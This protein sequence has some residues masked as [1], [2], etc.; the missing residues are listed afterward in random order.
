MNKMAFAVLVA[1]VLTLVCGRG[2]AAHVT[3]RC[4]AGTA[5]DVANDAAFPTFAPACSGDLDGDNKVTVDEIIAGVNN[6]LL[7][8]APPAAVEGRYEGAGR[9]I[10]AGTCNE[11]T[12]IPRAV[13]SAVVDITRQDG[14]AFSA[15]LSGESEGTVFSLVLRGTVDAAGTFTAGVVSGDSVTGAFGGKLLGNEVVLSYSLQNGPCAVAG[16]LVATRTQPPGPGSCKT[17]SDCKEKTSYCAKVPGN[18]DGSGFCWQPWPG[19]CLQ[20]YDPVC[21]C[22]GKT[23]GNACSADQQS[24]NVRHGGECEQPPA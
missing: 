10:L 23:Y 4:L 6:A 18:C 17:D 20:I 3:E 1:A 21:G 13:D 15:T 14:S 8:C 19:A 5:P 11:P 16:S 12:A 9:E 22:D 24:M 7:G 2:T